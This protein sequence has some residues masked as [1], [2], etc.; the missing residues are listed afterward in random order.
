MDAGADLL[1]LP[2]DACLCICIFHE[3]DEF[4]ARKPRND[5]RFAERAAQLICNGAKHGVAPGVAISIIDGLEIV[6]IDYIECVQPIL[7][8]MAFQKFLYLRFQCASVPKACQRIVFRFV[9]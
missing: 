9:L 2:G 8:I 7:C 5:V 4:I 6:H 3:H 1:R